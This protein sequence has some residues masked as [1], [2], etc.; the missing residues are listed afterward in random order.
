[1]ERFLRPSQVVKLIGLSIRQLYELESRGEF[2][3]KVQL[4]KNSVAW[5]EKD[6]DDWLKPRLAAA[7]ARERA[8]KHAGKPKERTP[9]STVP[10]ET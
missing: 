9:K 8:L 7:K 2:P 1:M 4:G 6:L 5:R 10:P 3:A